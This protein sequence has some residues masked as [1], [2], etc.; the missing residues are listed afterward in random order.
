[1]AFDKKNL[2]SIIPKPK[3]KTSAWVRTFLLIS[4]VLLVIILIFYALLKSENGSLT[5]KKQSLEQQITEIKDSNFYALEKNL[6]AVAKRM[7][8]FN[9]LAVDHT[10]SSNILGLLKTVCHP[11]VQL[12]SLDFA[13]QDY[14]ITLGGKTE[15]FQILGQQILAL[16]LFKNDNGL[17]GVE[18]SKVSLDEEGKVNFS[19]LLNF[20]PKFF[21]P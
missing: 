2:V 10:I 21:K 13:T 11:K 1:M 9:K 3:P 19:L 17:K 4:I 16:L 18:I 12:T 6:S 14:Q 8:E 5:N 15:N 7:K 20:S